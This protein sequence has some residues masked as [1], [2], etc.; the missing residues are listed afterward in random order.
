MG[1]AGTDTEV[2]T[3]ISA[4]GG[5]IDSLRERVSNESVGAAL[6]CARLCLDDALLRGGSVPVAQPTD[7]P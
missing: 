4:I 7:E 3:E 6:G 1:K 2:E 5:M